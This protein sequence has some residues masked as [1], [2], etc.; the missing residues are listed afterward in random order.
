[1]ETLVWLWWAGCGGRGGARGGL[2]RRLP[3]SSERV[4]CVVEGGRVMWVG[5][6]V[7]GREIRRGEYKG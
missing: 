5:A 2:N 1:M 3:W 4:G 6:R 7:W